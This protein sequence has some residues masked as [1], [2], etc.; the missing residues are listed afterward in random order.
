MMSATVYQ[1]GRLP[2]TGRVDKDYLAA[3]R[4]L[5]LAVLWL[6]GLIGW[7]VLAYVAEPVSQD[8]GGGGTAAAEQVFDGRGKWTGY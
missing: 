3:R 1:P 8:Q 2:S 4:R 6:V 7:G 5:A